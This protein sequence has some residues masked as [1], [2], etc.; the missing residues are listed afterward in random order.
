MNLFERLHGQYIHSRRVRVLCESLSDDIPPN[1]KVLD[2]GCGDG[3]LASLIMNDRPDVEISGIDVLARSQTKIPVSL[4]D[5]MTIPFPDNSYDAVMFVD[6]LHHTRD[7]MVLLREAVRVARK[8]ILIKDHHLN[9]LLAGP[10]LRFMDY[11][12]NARHGVSLPYYYWPEQ[13]WLEAF[14]TLG[15]RVGRC[16]KDLRL[17]PRP[18][19]WVFD[20]SL[21]FVRRLDLVA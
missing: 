21:H 19:S 3:L 11:V 20:R 1:A 12:G 7:P 16:R 14:S 4:F 10:T 9:G 8:T 6:V 15:V 18:M 13:K 17:Y 2:V 5:G